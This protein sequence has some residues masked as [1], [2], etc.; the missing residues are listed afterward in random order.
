MM[1]SANAAGTDV[2]P[3]DPAGSRNP[4]GQTRKV[5]R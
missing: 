1:P 5:R 3:M 2:D 4:S